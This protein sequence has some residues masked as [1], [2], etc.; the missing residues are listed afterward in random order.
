MKYA[1]EQLVRPQHENG[2]DYGHGR[3]SVLVRNGKKQLLHIAGSKHWGGIGAERCYSQSEIVLYPVEKEIG[4]QKTLTE[5]RMT[6]Q[7]WAESAEAIFAHLGARFPIELID[8][9]HTLLLDEPGDVD[10]PPPRVPGSKRVH[11]RIESAHIVRI[12]IDDDLTYRFAEHPIL[13][14]GGG[15]ITYQTPAGHERERRTKDLILDGYAGDRDGAVAAFLQIYEEQVAE[16]RGRLERAAHHFVY[17]DDRLAEAKQK[18]EILLR[19]LT[20]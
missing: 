13:K 20:Q 7:K 2:C 12:F 10:G 4:K 11:P 17:T 6:P 3:R 8:L 15:K 1:D 5:G 9:K 16:A 14:Q 18:I 19:E